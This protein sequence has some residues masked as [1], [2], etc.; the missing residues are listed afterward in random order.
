MFSFCHSFWLLSEIVCSLIQLPVM[1]VSCCGRCNAYVHL[2]HNVSIFIRKTKEITFR[3]WPPD[4]GH[5]FKRKSP[6]NFLIGS[7]SSPTFFYNFN[8]QTITCNVISSS[9]VFVNARDFEYC[10]VQFNSFIHLLSLHTFRARMLV[11]LFTKCNSPMPMN[12]NKN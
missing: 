2:M 7:F 8:I 12:F 4:S 10:A 1:N 3:M 6:E 9:N 5:L 11:R